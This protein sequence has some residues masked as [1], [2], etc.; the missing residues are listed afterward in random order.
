MGERFPY[1]QKSKQFGSAHASVH[2]VTGLKPLVLMLFQGF[3]QISSTFVLFGFTFDIL[4]SVDLM[5]TFFLN[6]G[7]LDLRPLLSARLSNVVGVLFLAVWR[8]VDGPNQADNLGHPKSLFL[9]SIRWTASLFFAECHLVNLIY[10]DQHRLIASPTGGSRRT[11]PT[12]TSVHWPSLSP[13][14]G[15]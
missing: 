13:P 8:G 7:L 12:S 3:F 11:Q 4:E 10:S 6:G 1:I 5:S 14:I 9:V 15:N 2:F